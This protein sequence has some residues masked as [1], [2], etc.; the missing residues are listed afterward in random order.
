MILV[1][2]GAG[3]IGSNLVAALEE[4]GQDVMICDRMDRDEKWRNIRKRKNIVTLIRPERLFEEM[5]NNLD[6]IVHLGARTDTTEENVGLILQDNYYFSQQLYH[7]AVLHS[8]PFIYA[9]SAATY[10]TGDGPLNAYAWS[11]H[12]FDL[13]IAHQAQ[14]FDR[15]TWTGLRFFN[16]FG[17]N[18]YHKGKMRSLIAQ[19]WANVACGQ[20][21]DLFEDGT[22]QRD[23]VYVDDVVS[24]IKFF[25][26]NPTQ[27]LFDVGTGV[28][29]SFNDLANSVFSAAKKKSDIRYLPFP[30]QLKSR[31]QDYTRADL[32]PLRIASYAGV[33][34]PLELSVQRYVDRYLSQADPYR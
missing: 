33:F 22:Q 14:F 18:E 12:L 5:P 1:T 26:E 31:Y 7:S 30:T 25:L 28:P 32:E 11:K 20:P 9:S 19:N 8:V 10:G 34:E 13:W 21:F 17:P 6:S 3:F 4:A 27:G 23:F 24:V 2:G 29:R 16:V 15:S